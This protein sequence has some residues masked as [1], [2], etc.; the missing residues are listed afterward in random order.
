M[1]NWWV[2]ATETSFGLGSKVNNAYLEL[3]AG[4]AGKTAVLSIY[5]K[6]N[7]GNTVWSY[8]SDEI[9]IKAAQDTAL[10]NI[11]I[12]NT[13]KPTYDGT[14]HVIDEKWT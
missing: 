14:E 6:D 12:A 1:E 7:T 13:W 4:D 2:A 3:S 10:N 8:T 5:A 11:E 9:Q